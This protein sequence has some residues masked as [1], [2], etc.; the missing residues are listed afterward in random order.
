MRALLLLLIHRCSWHRSA[1]GEETLAESNANI[2]LIP[3]NE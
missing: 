2:S 1:S 3:T